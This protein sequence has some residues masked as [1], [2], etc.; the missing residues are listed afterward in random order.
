METPQTLSPD[1][2]RAL[3]PERPASG[4]KGTFGHLFVLAGSRGFTGAAKLTAMA[5][6]RSGA[7]L[8]T[9]GVPR[10]LA[11]VI[12][13][14]L[15]EPMSLPLPATEMESFAYAALEPA[16][17]FAADKQAVAMGPGLSP[18]PGT[19][20][21]AIEFTR[22]CPV[23]LLIDADG[24]NALVSDLGAL[25]AA[26][27]PRIL[28]P[29]P[30]EMARLTGCST[31]EIQDAREETAREFAASHRCVVVLKGHGT[32]IADPSGETRINPTGNSG[33]ATGGAGDVLSGLIGGLLAQGMAAF[34]AALLGAYL[35]GL[36]GDLAAQRKT[37]RALIA[38]D[39]IKSLPKAWRALEEGGL[40]HAN[41]R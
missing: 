36:A 21:F 39:L 27:A 22:R 23:P 17:A 19:Q 10:P 41:G 13:A 29:H 31:Q 9:V 7:G 18:H 33:M 8:V 11:D 15:L 40:P 24:L 30:G 16:L 14:G 4:H 35:H 28:T 25:D 38:R 2:M 20:R 37:E 32:V 12:A 26:P 6:A 5:A 3:L 34:P 1:Q